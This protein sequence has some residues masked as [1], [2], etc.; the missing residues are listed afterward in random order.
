MRLMITDELWGILEPLTQ[1]AKKYKCGASPKLT[2]RMFFE[3]LLYIA[4][5]GIPWRDLPGD[6]GRWEAVYGRFRRW[7]ESGSLSRFF[8]LL[9]ENPAFGDVRR[10]LIDSTIIRAHQHAVGARRSIKKLAG[11][12]PHANRALAAVGAGIPAK[13]C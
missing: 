6:F 12:A 11:N 2:N 9:T 8:E 13:S 1:A 4:R 7:I 5:T 3:A 10:A